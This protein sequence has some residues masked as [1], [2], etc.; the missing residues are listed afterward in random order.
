MSDDSK[1]DTD[2]IAEHGLH[3]F[4][5]QI[6]ESARK[7]YGITTGDL[8]PE[9]DRKLGEA[10]A[11]AVRA[12]FEA[13]A[14]AASKIVA[15]EL[16]VV[17]RAPKQYERGFWVEATTAADAL[18]EILR[19]SDEAFGWVALRDYSDIERDE[20]GMRPVTIETH[21]SDSIAFPA[22]TR[23]YAA[24]QGF[25]ATAGLPATRFTEDE[26]AAAVLDQL[27]IG[28]PVYIIESED[29]PGW[30]ATPITTGVLVSKDGTHA[31]VKVAGGPGTAFVDG[32][33][34][35]RVHAKQIA[36]DLWRELEDLP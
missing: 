8:P 15:V 31:R 28:A 23:D 10:A 14:P 19:E 34:I 24:A 1:Y 5:A 20:H 30:S 29:A 22:M 4:W 6:A 18:A 25:E 33:G 16:E 9:V 13:N 35:R 36:R 32:P 11:E 7:H 26:L 3:A 12:W 2:G 21:R 17:M 27:E